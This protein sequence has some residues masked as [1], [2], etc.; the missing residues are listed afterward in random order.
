MRSHLQLGSF[1]LLLFAPGRSW[2]QPS[3][4]LAIIAPSSV[5]GVDNLSL[6]VIVTNT[7]TEVLKLLKDPGGVLSTT[8]THKFQFDGENGSPLFT[9]VAA[10]YSFPAPLDRAQDFVVLSPGHSVNQEHDLAGLYNFTNI[11]AGEFEV[12]ASNKFIYVN[13]L[14]EL[15]V[16][17]ATIQT[18]KIKV[19]GQLASSKF[20]QMPT[21]YGLKKRI[22]YVGCT[23]ARQTLLA[24][25]AST[26]NSYV[27]A[28]SSY[29]AQI[30]SGTVRYTTWFGTYTATKSNLVRSVYNK[31]GT[32]AS[33][34]TY[35]CT[36]T[37]SG[38]YAYGYPDQPGYIYICG[39]F[40][41]TPN[42]GKDSR[43]GT[44]IYVQVEFAANGGIASNASSYEYFAENSPPLP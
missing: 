30:T 28:A 10:K 29:L 19:S 26:S 20:S 44:L 8:S 32:D 22:A 25:A 11:G 34:T 23:S 24:T 41:S 17:E 38:T 5:D 31:V 42:S 14:G 33:S 9:G 15:V 43:A 37:D 36:C 35:D 40:W 39:A 3:I 1:L 16:I 4:S 18:A 12:N 2:A 7:G 27:A 21:T 13:S 6:G